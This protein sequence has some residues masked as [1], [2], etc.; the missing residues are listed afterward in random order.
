M[1]MVHIAPTPTRD[2]YKCVHKFEQL[3]CT[4]GKPTKGHCVHKFAQ[5]I[6][7]SMQCL[8]T[9]SYCTFNDAVGFS[10]NCI[11]ALNCILNCNPCECIGFYHIA[12]SILVNCIELYSIYCNP[13]SCISMHDSCALNCVVFHCIAQCIVL[14]S[15]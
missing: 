15:A 11:P 8:R 9:L 6:C 13:F 1:I 3:Y 10:H 2:S 14:H 5:L 12:K 7:S 4:P